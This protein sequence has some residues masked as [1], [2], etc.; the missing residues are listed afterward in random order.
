[1]KSSEAVSIID[2]EAIQKIK[3]LQRPGRPNLLATLIDLYLETAQ[4]SMQEIRNAIQNKDLSLLSNAA[5]S[6]KSSSA[7]LGAV[8]FSGLCLQLE[9][10]TPAKLI[11][12]DVEQT[13]THLEVEF[14]KVCSELK[15][16]KIAA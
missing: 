4:E 1:M 9:N 6:L 16:L 7:N 12:E 5:H 11:S 8:Y 15:G 10:L 2:L 14:M 3:I 13:L